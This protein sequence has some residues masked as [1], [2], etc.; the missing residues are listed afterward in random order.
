MA[1]TQI[2]KAIQHNIDA[3]E[4][5]KLPVKV[6]GLKYSGKL[7]LPEKLYGREDEM[8]TLLDELMSI[9]KRQKKKNITFISGIS[10]IGKTG[11][12]MEVQAIQLHINLGR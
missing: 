12:V 6:E 4:E 8:T 1:L 2:L 11:I 3:L 5:E 10:G 9:C 7:Y